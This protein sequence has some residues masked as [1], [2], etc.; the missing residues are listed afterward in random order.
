MPYS[1][2]RTFLLLRRFPHLLA[3]SSY[4]NRLELLLEG[5]CKEGHTRIASNFLVQLK[6]EDPKFVPSVHCYNI[7]LHGWFR[8]RKLKMA[9]RLWSDMR[10]HG[11]LPTVDS[12]STN[13]EGLCRMQR[14]DQAMDLLEEMKTSGID[15]N[16]LTCNPIVDSLSKAGRFKEAL[17]FIE[18]FPLFGISPNIS[19]YN[20]LIKGFCKNGDLKGASNVLKIM[21]GRDVLPTSTTYS[22][23]FRYF[24]NFD[25]IEEGM[26]L[27]SK[28]LQFGYVPDHLTYQLLIKTLFENQR[29]EHALQL[30][31][32]M[33]RFGFEMDLPMSTMLLHLLCRLRRFE[34]ACYEFEKMLKRGLLPQYVTYHR[35]INELRRVGLIK[36]E[37]KL[38][39]LMD[40]V[41][42]STTLPAT[43]SKKDADEEK[44]RRKLIMVKAQVLS[45]AL[46][47]CKDTDEV[48][49]L[50]TSVETLVERAN[51]LMEKIRRRVY[52]MKSSL[53]LEFLQENKCL[54]KLLLTKGPDHMKS[55][56]DPYVPTS[57]AKN[58]YFPP[59]LAF[60]RSCSAKLHFSCVQ[61]GTKTK[62]K[63]REEDER[64]LVSLSSFSRCAL[65]LCVSVA[66]AMRIRCPSGLFR[67][68]R[69]CGKHK[70]AEFTSP[71]AENTTGME[72][73]ASALASVGVSSREDGLV[74]GNTDPANVGQVM[75]NSDVFV[76]HGR[77]NDSSRPNG[78]NAFSAKKRSYSDSAY[79]GFV[80]DKISPIHVD[81]PKCVRSP[82][83]LGKEVNSEQF[84]RYQNDEMQFPPRPPSSIV[85]HSPLGY[86]PE[87]L[88]SK[89]EQS[90]TMNPS[91]M[92]HYPSPIT[93]SGF[94]SAFHASKDAT[95]SSI[96]TSQSAADEGSRTGIKG[97]EVVNVA[98]STSVAFD[99]SMAAVLPCSRWPK[100][101]IIKPDS[102]NSSRPH[103][104]QNVGRQMTIFYA[105]QA[106]VFDDVHPN[107]AEVIMA[108]A[109]SSGVSWSTTYSP[110]PAIPPAEIKLQVGEH[111]RHNSTL[112][113]LIKGNTEIGKTT[114][115][116]DVQ[117]FT[118]EPQ[119][120]SRAV[121]DGRLVT[122]VSLPRTGGSE[123]FGGMRP[124]GGGAGSLSHLLAVALY[125]RILMPQIARLGA[126]VLPVVLT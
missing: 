9:E 43:Y 71:L 10:C 66:A 26:N 87:V 114:V 84:A 86:R 110:K 37:E 32:D 48:T 8:L 68:G 33:N 117:S 7:L 98:A 4:N 15:P 46:K 81:N 56:M 18:K 101:P 103:E 88:A 38:S 96:L 67:I 126:S 3:P 82:K 51:K 27:Y 78:R 121:R 50:R 55:I 93:R 42:H 36:L 80:T 35:L 90:R 73:E 62:P 11:I 118:A 60:T 6:S 19:T 105:G 2:I 39:A 58:G 74:S 83:M 89:C 102:S 1:A 53:H 76:I 40:S 49:K 64:S 20:S 17:G 69:S 13:I 41:P 65:Y 63:E 21:I 85:L 91:S 75:N 92:V 54:L 99:R 79:M 124:Y 24:A 34:E 95:V 52:G 111:Q 29:L 94:L 115:K 106:H 122:Q 113:S 59:Q 30:I 77:K 107:K 22:H 61:Q 45:E 28:M 47:E 112:P 16:L 23:Y 14:P 120:S 44:K 123:D 100:S 72:T 116:G 97:C 12:Y 57:Q 108:L 104:M 70:S 109:G 119:H 31:K 125:F 5:L 25:K